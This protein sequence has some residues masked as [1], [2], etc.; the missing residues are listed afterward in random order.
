MQDRAWLQ[1]AVRAHYVRAFIFIEKPATVLLG[2]QN[3]LFIKA[4]SVIEDVPKGH[5]AHTRLG[6][7]R[8]LSARAT[9][10]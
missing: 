8:G 6:K 7:C 10:D 1:R 2:V 4:F 9:R 5:F 3:K